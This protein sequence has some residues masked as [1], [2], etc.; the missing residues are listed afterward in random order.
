[1]AYV[2]NS[3]I[4]IPG[5]GLVPRAAPNSPT[6]G[7]IYYD[8]TA[9]KIYGYNGT[10][11][12]ALSNQY[13]GFGGEMTTYAASG[14]TYVVHTFLSSG[15]FISHGATDVDSLV[16]NLYLRVLAQLIFSWSLVEAEVVM[17]HLTQVKAEAEVRED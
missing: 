10:A 5:F 8:A 12:I 7:Q 1:M 4:N 16:V 6:A 13:I 14:V 15:I 2:K 17:V 9:D 11:W 3:M